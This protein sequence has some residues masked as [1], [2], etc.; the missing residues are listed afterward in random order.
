MPSN[1]A[2]VIERIIDVDCELRD[3]WDWVLCEVASGGEF[4]RD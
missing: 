2:Y 3:K 4:G 1:V